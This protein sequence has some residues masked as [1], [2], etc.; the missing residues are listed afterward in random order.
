VMSLSKTGMVDILFR[1]GEEVVAMV[2]GFAVKVDTDLFAKGQ[3]VQLTVNCDDPMLHSQEPVLQTGLATF[4]DLVITDSKSTA[5]HGLTFKLRFTS[6]APNL[7]I[8]D[9]GDDSWFFR[10]SPE[11]GFLNGDQLFASNEFNQRKLYILRAGNV[12]ELKPSVIGGSI[13]PVIF[14]GENH[15]SFISDGSMT[16]TELSY[17][18]TYWGV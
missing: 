12:I 2:Q 4:E 13:W 8:V 6:N 9:P 7:L 1:R 10:I 5:P 17:Y 11:G 18:E 3:V 16:W 14:P 15:L